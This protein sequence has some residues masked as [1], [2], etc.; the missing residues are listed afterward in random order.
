MTDKELRVGI[1]GADNQ[2]S[3]AKIS[4]VPAVKNVPGTYETPG[5]E[6]ALHNSQLMSAV[7]H[8]A[9]QQASRRVPA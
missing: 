4:H 8:S 5:F 7:R 1:V 6:R 3:W 2:D 9:E